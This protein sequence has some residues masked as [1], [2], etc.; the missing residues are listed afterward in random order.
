[1]SRQK[2]LSVELDFEG[3]GRDITIIPVSTA[4]YEA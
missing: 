1:M 3:C 4:D 2:L